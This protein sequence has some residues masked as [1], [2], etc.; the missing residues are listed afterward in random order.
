M[1]TPKHFKMSDRNE[2][3]DFIHKNSFGILVSQN[4]GKI[5]ATHLPILL[6]ENEGENGFLYGHMAKAN[7]QWENISD[8]VL[9][10]FP[11]A[12]KYISPTWYDS[13]QT[14]PT[15]SYLSV[16]VYGK[17]TILDDRDSKE[18][19]VREIVKY[20]E[21]EN[22]SY[23]IGNLKHVTFEGLL[24]GITAFKIEI[25]EIEGKKKISQNHPETRQKLVIGELEK[26]NDDD[27]KEIIAGMKK[28]LG[29]KNDTNK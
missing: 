17:I 18:T 23:K 9:V 7:R 12:H 14:V 20:F 26:I 2:I 25:T 16:H 8:D 4:E 22:S 24:R 29:S 21:G 6:K 3:N 1:Y 5:I 11:G 19:A 28:N 13:D 15:W 27:S 10:I